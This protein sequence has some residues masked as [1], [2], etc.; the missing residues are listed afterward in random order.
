M[1]VFQQRSIQHAAQPIPPLPSAPHRLSQGNDVCHV[2]SYCV[3]TPSLSLQQ[4]RERGDMGSKMELPVR[5]VLCEHEWLAIDSYGRLIAS[6]ANPQQYA[7]K[8]KTRVMYM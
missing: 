6:L 8:R 2:L 7:T 5:R 4:L 1:V 3:K